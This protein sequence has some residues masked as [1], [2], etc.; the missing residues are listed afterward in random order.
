MQAV[1]GDFQITV[2]DAVPA[3]GISKKDAGKISFL[4]SESID[5][6][7]KP[8]GQCAV[9]DMHF[10]PEQ[11]VSKFCFQKSAVLVFLA[12]AVFVK[13]RDKAPVIRH[14]GRLLTY[15]SDQFMC[16]TGKLAL[17]KGRNF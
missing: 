4:P 16:E 1:F 11:V 12:V 7:R 14:G 3:L 13:V 8:K 2:D 10:Q 6:N 17:E 5:F 15:L 9:F